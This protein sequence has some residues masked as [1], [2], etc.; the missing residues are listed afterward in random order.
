MLYLL[1]SACLVLEI[2]SNISRTLVVAHLYIIHSMASCDGVSLLAATCLISTNAYTK[3]TALTII[4]HT[5]RTFRRTDRTDSSRWERQRENFDET[6]KESPATNWFPMSNFIQSYASTVHVQ[7]AFFPSST[8]C[9]L[10]FFFSRYSLFCFRLRCTLHWK[11][12]T[13]LK[14]TTLSYFV[15]LFDIC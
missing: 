15:C 14:H 1:S 11:C 13:P 4:H 7:L 5:H 6:K 12:Y 9:F 3:H 8:D 10:Q 2:F